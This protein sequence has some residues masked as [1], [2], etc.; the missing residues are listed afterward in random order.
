MHQFDRIFRRKN[1]PTINFAE[2]H[3]TILST[4]FDEFCLKLNCLKKL[5]LMFKSQSYAMKIPWP[6]CILKNIFNR[7]FMFI[8]IV[9]F[10]LFLPNGRL[11]KLV[12]FPGDWMIKHNFISNYN[13]KVSDVPFR[14]SS[15]SCF[16][17]NYL[18]CTLKFS[19]DPITRII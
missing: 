15:P 10:L 18:H 4:K 7:R 3:F 11:E 9:I 5:V 2:N 17:D 12:E 14:N 19:G 13:T 16:F 1:W 8:C 6:C